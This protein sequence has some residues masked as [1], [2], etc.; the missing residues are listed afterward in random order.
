MYIYIYIY[1]GIPVATLPDSSPPL[2]LR[3]GSA[4][5]PYE[6]CRCTSH[7]KNGLLRFKISQLV[8]LILN[9]L[10]I[11]FYDPGSFTLAVIVKT[12]IGT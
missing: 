11:K 7:K 12:P 4:Y 10:F 9:F 2:A 6:C 8:K 1:T 5:G 3:G